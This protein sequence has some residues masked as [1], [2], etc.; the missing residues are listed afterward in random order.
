MRH[1][2][3]PIG[4][5]NPSLSASLRAKTLR[6]ACRRALIILA[7]L[8]ATPWAPPALADTVNSFR[9]AHGLPSL[10][11]SGT[12]QAMAQRCAGSM[13]ARRSLDPAGF[14]E[15]VRAGARAENVAFGC[16]TESCAISMWE[17]SVGHRA[18]MLNSG[19]RSYGL[20]SAAG[21]GRRYWCLE[22]GR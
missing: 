8:A 6:L 10:H 4:G 20:A 14:S 15:R 2:G 7:A 5:S 22:L 16:A 11:R 19:V 3:N 1:R 12:M 21:G 13:A 17:S 18:N 9:H